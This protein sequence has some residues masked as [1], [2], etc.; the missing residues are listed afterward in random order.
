MSRRF[1]PYTV[2]TFKIHCK[3]GETVR[4]IPIGDVH[5]TTKRCA[6]SK[7]KENLERIKREM[8]S[9]QVFIIGMGDY[10]DFMSMSERINIERCDLHETTEEKLDEV[11]DRHVEIF[12][13][14][15]APFKGRII[16]LLEGN[17]YGRFFKTGITT[18][19]KLCEKLGCEYLGSPAFV[20]IQLD[21]QGRH[22]RCAFDIFANHVG[23]TKGGRTKSGSINSVYKM[24]EIAEADVY[25]AAHDHQRWVYPTCRIRLTNTGH[26]RTQDRHIIMAR[27]GSFYL[28]YVDGQS[29]YVSEK[30][31]SPA[32]LG[33]TYTDVT[34][35]R[36][37][38]NR[39]VVNG[40]EYRD[41]DV[42]HVELSG[43]LF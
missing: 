33:L 37:F 8:L 24:L 22:T 32:N 3:L 17:H 36:V 21:V 20:R 16:G 6:E 43:G 27:T 40:K 29:N 12:A 1:G 2:S 9:K 35:K 14:E 39:R 18:T 15:W 26:V 25:Y 4:I 38:E 41:G 7:Y 31:L 34:V 10:D 28:G 13:K 42:L 23:T 5:R 30:M 11:M 19:Q